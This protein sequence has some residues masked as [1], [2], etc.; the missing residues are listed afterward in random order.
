MSQV[1]ASD[2]VVQSEFAI[3][4]S[5]DGTT[6][7]D[8]SGYAN[9][10]KPDGGERDTG[11]LYTFDGDTAVVTAGKRKPQTIEM[12]IVYTEGANDITAMLQG[13]YENKTLVYLR[14]APKGMTTGNWQFQ[15]QGYVVSPIQPEGDATSSDAVLVTVKFVVSAMVQSVQA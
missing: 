7:T 8:I 10:V 9:S 6:W 15:G 11:A 13:W 5:E 3:E 2:V 1:P 4:V 14:Y 12:D